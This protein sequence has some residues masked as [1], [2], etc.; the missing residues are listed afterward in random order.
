MKSVVE[1]D[2]NV[3]QEKLA[4]L[5]TDPLRNPAWMDDVEKI[6]ALV[7][8]LGKP[9]STYRLVPK[10]ENSPLWHR[11]FPRTTDRSETYP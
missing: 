2:I 1:L 5:F 3:G 10:Q 6:E 11:S 7:G 9:G 8:D 4:E